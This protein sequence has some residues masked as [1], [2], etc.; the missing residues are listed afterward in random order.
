M[1]EAELIS[2]AL[3][4]L[5][6]LQTAEAIKAT[7]LP[8]NTKAAKAGRSIARQARKQ[9]ESRTGKPVVSGQN[10]LASG[11]ANSVLKSSLLKQSKR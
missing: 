5:S 4:K 1:T 7:G 10:Y 8:E 11:A 3:A 9:M 2:T 6:T